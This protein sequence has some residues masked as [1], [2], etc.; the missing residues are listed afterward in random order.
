MVEV[1]EIETPRL[2]LRAWREAD[3]RAWLAMMDDPEV[4]RWLGGP[5]ASAENE[6][7]F[8]RFKTALEGRGW[9]LWAC[10]RMADGAVIGAIGVR[11]VFRD[12]PLA[13]S[14]EVAWRLG[15]PFWGA[16]YASE[17]AAAAISWAFD[18]LGV[19]EVVAFTSQANLRSRAVMERIGMVRDPGRDFLHPNLAKGHPLR[20]HF[21]YVARREAADQ[22]S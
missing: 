4:S 11:P 14:I 10:E 20:A 1:V 6:A 15:R 8:N 5:F 2:R 17:G 21:V 19:N 18:H 12:H 7:S 13:G 3:R 16:G 9:D 22:S